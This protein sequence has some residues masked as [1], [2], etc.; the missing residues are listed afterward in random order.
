V[1]TSRHRR[2]VG[3]AR[4]RCWR[5]PGRRRG[6]A[7]RRRVR[8]ERPHESCSRTGSRSAARSYQS[9]F[10]APRA[11]STAAKKSSSWQ[12]LRRRRLDRRQVSEQPGDGPLPC[13]TA[14]HD[15]DPRHRRPPRHRYEELTTHVEDRL[16]E[17]SG[18]VEQL[19]SDTLLSASPTFQLDHP[20]HRR[21]R[22]RHAGD[23][24]GDASGNIQPT[25][26]EDTQAWVAARSRAGRHR[27][28]PTRSRSALPPIAEASGF[29]ARNVR[30]T[31]ATGNMGAQGTFYYIA[32]RERR[33]GRQRFVGYSLSGAVN[34]SPESL[35]QRRSPCGSSTRCSRLPSPRRRPAR[36]SGSRRAGGVAGPPGHEHR[37]PNPTGRARA[38]RVKPAVREPH[39]RPGGDTLQGPT[40]D[41][42]HAE[43]PP[44]LLP[45]VRG[46]PAIGA[47]NPALIGQTVSLQGLITKDGT[48]H[49]QLHERDESIC[50][51]SSCRARL[52]L[53]QMLFV[54]V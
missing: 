30:S 24:G 38:G 2:D 12:E 26:L 47:L 32:L 46:T 22:G 41:P 54:S 36:P 17:A 49:G 6:P 29:L 8:A 48:P 23:D 39:G 15:R 21:H 53:T 16:S 31:T 9:V 42:G 50:W 28:R 11:R 33:R 20:A 7:R 37:S 19:R 5:R 27:R 52:H 35:D 3:L 10:A 1:A 14:G 18:H 44:L 34:S 45:R 51:S 4:A 25:T 40:V 43:G 13:T